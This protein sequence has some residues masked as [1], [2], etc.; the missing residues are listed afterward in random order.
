[1]CI[2]SFRNIDS[3][4][5]CF[6]KQL[7][8]IYGENAQGKTSILEAI[9]Y[10]ALTKSFRANNEVI[11]LKYNQD[12]FDIE[13]EFI[14]DE[15]S[16]F[17]IRVYYSQ[18]EN[19]HIFYNENQIRKFSEIVGIVPVILLSL[20]D[21][22]IS[23][24]IPA[25]RRRFLDILLSQVNPLYLQ[26]LQIYKRSLQNRN[27]LLKDIKDG[28]ASPEALF[29]WNKQLCE[30]G[31]FI[32]RSRKSFVDFLNER[33][34]DYYDHIS[35]RDE[36][37]ETIYRS[38]V[39]SKKEDLPDSS[40]E[41]IYENTL[42]DN[43]D[44][45]VEFQTTQTGPHRED[46]EFIKDGHPLKSFGSQ[47]ENKTFLIALKFAESDYL[48]KS[49]NKKPM[50]LLDDIFGELDRIRIHNLMRFVN[51]VGQTFITTTIRDKFL[52]LEIENL[53]LFH[54]EEGKIYET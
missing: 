22:D 44:R 52:D 8:I 4:E 49:M 5:I 3:I 23:Y 2:Q 53:Q 45:D 35:E 48:K 20:E 38:A 9:Y 15:G 7:N 36:K 54:M 21:L 16:E 50:L 6:D 39:L 11:A 41:Q 18:K 27:K 19:K 28:Q 46:L 37:I 17:R 40:L 12:F 25:K 32:I 34:S 13:G 1:L 51:Q 42:M 33:L 24:G 31:S 10:L 47:G 30:Y 14:N 43:Q 26:A 29:P